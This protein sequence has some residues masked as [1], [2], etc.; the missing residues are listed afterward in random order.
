L[1]LARRGIARVVHKPVD[2]IGLQ[3]A[4]RQLSA[5]ERSL[6]S[7][8]PKF[9]GS[10]PS[11][12][13]EA[14]AAEARRAFGGATPAGREPPRVDFQSDAEVLSL[15][16]SAFARIR[17]LAGGDARGPG[18]PFPVQG[19][20]GAVPLAPAPTRAPSSAR[21][22][23]EK[24]AGFAGRS[25]VVAVSDLSVLTLLCK[26]LEQL[27]A[28]T[29]PARDGQQALELVERFWPD[30]VIADTL[31][32]GL[33]GFELCRRLRQDIA[34]W[35]VP[36][37]L[38]AWKEYLLER[39]KTPGKEGLDAASIAP[40][41]EQCLSD[42]V[43]LERH[44]VRS[45]EVHGRLQTE[46]PR[47]LLELA[48]RRSEPTLL[49]LHD[50]KLK[51]ELALGEGCVLDARLFEAG[52]LVGSG[53]AV[54]GPFLGTRSGRFRLNC[55]SSTPAGELRVPWKQALEHIIARARRACVRLAAP[56]ALAE[57]ER[58][59]LDSAG[60][61]R[62]LAETPGAPHGAIHALLER[63]SLR[64]LLPARG[65]GSAAAAE[66]GFHLLELA[67]RG[68][69]LALLD[70]AGNDLL[71]DG[72]R[73]MAPASGPEPV[74]VAEPLA[75]AAASGPVM[76]LGEA[77]FDAVRVAPA[78][79]REPGSES[80]NPEPVPSPR[81]PSPARSFGAEP[82]LSA[83]GPP[84]D[85]AVDVS[86]EGGFGAESR[87]DLRERLRGVAAPVLVT[88]AAASIAFVGMRAL[89]GGVASVAP[90]EPAS[91][92]SPEPRAADGTPVSP[93]NKPSLAPPNEPTAT[94]APA[95]TAAETSLLAEQKKV[96]ADVSFSAE[97][98]ELPLH[99][100]VRPGHGLL[101]VR[102]WEPRQIYVDGVFMGNYATR[103]IPLGP[104]KYQLRLG[105]GDRSMESSVE[106]LAGRRTRLVAKPK[107]TP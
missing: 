99:A 38:L 43:E 82:E 45:M 102:S 77:V 83:E 101:E 96:P 9:S 106:V 93:A 84:S 103:L 6:P 36:V 31:L 13:V 59:E 61:A 17:G 54:L 76:D 2:A 107:V 11:E 87:P 97:L 50:A 30:A 53:E 92:G 85:D 22:P 62:Y 72:P 95:A 104:G 4:V 74:R 49:R 70:R 47:A 20:F 57:I 63:G 21:A 75:L 65:A 51:F 5:G 71:S 10:T 94:P 79:D 3:R 55:L 14:I 18:A 41:L 37:A 64:S 34:L 33:D 19:P 40:A 81:T 48:C 105:N 25:F 66:I 12:L 23:S 29:R 1:R 7:P 90:V 86:T 56:A 89:G 69:V 8:P 68:A 44:L 60:A 58:C 15:L 67:R 28:S 35:D 39:A 100:K 16:W 32:P 91:E 52:K 26:L 73:I 80:R 98:L 78:S 42:R 88:L 27:G 46:S 24:A